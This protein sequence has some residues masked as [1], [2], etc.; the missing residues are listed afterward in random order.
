AAKSTAPEG[1]KI[2]APTLTPLR[3]CNVFCYRTP[4]SRPGLH[5]FGP[6]GLRAT[7][8]VCPTAS[9]GPATLLKGA[10][11]VLIGRFIPGTDLRFEIIDIDAIDASAI[12]GLG[13]GGFGN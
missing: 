2:P 13:V 7:L 1:R 9:R 5:S 3:G 6:P 8:T 10:V 11:P 4:G 12:A